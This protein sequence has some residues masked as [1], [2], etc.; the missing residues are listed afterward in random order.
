MIADTNGASQSVGITKDQTD[1]TLFWRPRIKD[2]WIRRAWSDR[3]PGPYTS[4]LGFYNTGTDLYFDPMFNRA[5]TYYVQPWRWV[6]FLSHCE[7]HH[8]QVSWR[9]FAGL[10]YPDVMFQTLGHTV[11]VGHALIKVGSRWNGAEW[12]ITESVITIPPQCIQY[13]AVRSGKVRDQLLIFQPLPLELLSD[14]C[15]GLQTVEPQFIVAV[16]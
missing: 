3:N 12:V 8:I 9:K 7:P 13:V 1:A 14:F 6:P 2:Y 11:P 10:Y 4:I 16:K 5:D 15:P